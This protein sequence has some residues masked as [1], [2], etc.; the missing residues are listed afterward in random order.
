MVMFAYSIGP[1]DYGWEHLPLVENVMARMYHDH[2]KNV[3]RFG[4][5]IEHAN[6]ADIV[7]AFVKAR[8]LA[9]KIGWEG[10]FRDDATP[11]VF[12]VPNEQDFKFDYGFVWKQDNN[13]QTFV[14][15]PVRMMHL[16]K[17]LT[18]HDMIVG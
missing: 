9:R 10:D 11:R 12:W 17:H 13:G 3:V 18:S 4:E 5:D 14:I 8:E 2:L 7:V 6:P 16:E 15:S 1:I